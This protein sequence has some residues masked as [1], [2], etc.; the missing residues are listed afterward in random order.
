MAAVEVKFGKDAQAR[1][2]AQRLIAAQSKQI[3][4]MSSWLR[5]GQTSAP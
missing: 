1:A 3:G 5:T 4:E 2:F